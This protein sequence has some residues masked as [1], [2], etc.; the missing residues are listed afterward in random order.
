MKRWLLTFPLLMA[1]LSVLSGGASAR[2]HEGPAFLAHLGAA[3]TWAVADHAWTLGVDPLVAELEDPEATF[4]EAEEEREKERSE[5][6]S[7]GEA[8]PLAT[9][10]DPWHSP[11]FFFQETRVRVDVIVSHSWDTPEARRHPARAPPAV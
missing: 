5:Q 1:L 3:T 11:L 6:R 4:E 7:P 8:G 2:G 9:L 10:S